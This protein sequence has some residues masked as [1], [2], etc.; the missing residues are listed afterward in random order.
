MTLVNVKKSEPGLY[1][2]VFGDE[3]DKAA[4]IND[5]DALD[6]LIITD[7]A[8]LEIRAQGI[9]GNAGCLL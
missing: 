9:N 8:R 2:V 6:D 3:I 4:V 7:A 5:S 1:A